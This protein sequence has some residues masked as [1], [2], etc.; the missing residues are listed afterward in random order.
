MASEVNEEIM[1]SSAR[2]RAA[3]PSGPKLMTA[4]DRSARAERVWQKHLS[5]ALI[6]LDEFIARRRGR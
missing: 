2:I 6:T 3:E 5:G 4:E 1:T